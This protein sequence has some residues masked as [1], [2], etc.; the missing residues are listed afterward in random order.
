MTSAVILAGG[1]GTR[2]RSVVPDLPKP[3]AP[4]NARPFLEYQMGYWITQGINHFVLSVGYRYKTIIDY[5]GAQFEG[6]SLDYVIE[7]TP[8]GT[9]GGLV[10]A[11]KKVSQQENFLLLNGDTYFEIELKNLINFSKKTDADWCFSLFRTNEKGRYL[12]MDILPDGQIASLQSELRSDERLANGGVYLVNPRALSSL[13]I[14][15]GYK[16]SLEEDIFPA[17]M[18]FGQRFFGKEFQNT[19]IDIG[20]PD[21]YRRASTLLSK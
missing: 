8:L 10:L 13:E 4:I 3:M 2:L 1:L 15:S 9:G 6:A 18:A 19:F 16:V 12:G 17:A 21:D 7:E 20:V 5:F 14:L 11:S